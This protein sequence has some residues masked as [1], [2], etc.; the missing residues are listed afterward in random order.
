[1]SAYR[2]IFF[3]GGFTC[4]ADS[5]KLNQEVIDKIHQANFNKLKQAKTLHDVAQ[6]LGFKP[7]ALSYIL[8]KIPIDKKYHNFDIPKKSGGTRTINAPCLELKNL[9]KRLAELLQDCISTINEEKKIKNTLSHGFR[10]KYSIITNANEHTK[11][12]YILNIDLE[13]F[14]GQINFGRV[15]GFF[16]KNKNFNLDPRIATILAQIACHN[17]QLPQGSPCSPVISN[18]IG[19]P[20]DIKLA[21][22]AKKTGC[23]YSRYADDLT[24]STNNRDFP[25]ELAILTNESDN[26]WKAGKE[27]SSIIIKNRFSINV[28]KT[29]MQYKESR[30]DVTGLIV[31]NKVNIR[32]EYWR[33]VRAMANTLFKTGGFYV[34]NFEKDESGKI[35]IKKLEGDIKKIDGMFAFIDS[36]D[37]FN[38]IKDKTNKLKQSNTSLNSRELYYKRF[39]F[40]KNFYS[41]ILPLVICEGKT[42]NIYIQ[43]ALLSLATKFPQLIENKK[44][45]INFL[46]YTS[47]LEYIFP[48]RGGTGDLK[49]FIFGDKNKS[50]SS[51]SENFGYYKCTPIEN[52]IIILIDNDKGANQIF[53]SIKTTRKS[54][55][56]IDGSHDFYYISKNLY[57]IAIP[58]IN[59]KDTMMEDYFDEEVL[60]TEITGK[61]FSRKDE[62]D[63]KHEYGKAWFAEK[64]IKPNRDH[65]NF[66]RFEP[67]LRRIRSV[68]EDYKTKCIPSTEKS[69]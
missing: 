59:N 19:H 45:K 28:K 4:M 27:L 10:R 44:M 52:P 3:L 41:P 11:K 60:K 39:I 46:K 38:K 17:N 55:D 16:I 57:I 18:L 48:S 30:Q 69:I 61:K 68:L 56:T 14:F 35:T 36:V 43:S 24:F 67:I 34:N 29:R 5:K 22:L 50:I 58:K 64:V 13:N 12:R 66:E 32:S 42:D 33:T 23:R 6:L 54:S 49:N 20:L 40:F 7:Q 63:K 51:Y 47:S 26:L 25:I 9:Q 8:Y 1:M 62:Y 2:P 15:R 65:I 53:S 37:K 21:N 31:N